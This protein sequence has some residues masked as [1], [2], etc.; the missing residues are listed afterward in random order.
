MKY[1]FFYKQWKKNNLSQKLMKLL[2][3]TKQLFG[4]C[5]TR[6]MCEIQIVYKKKKSLVV[7]KICMVWKNTCK[8]ALV[9]VSLL[10]CN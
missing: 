4:R 3:T 10:N 7:P 1:T 9:C 5:N 8:I 6:A 2:T